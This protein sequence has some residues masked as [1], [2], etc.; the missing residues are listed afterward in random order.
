[1]AYRDFQNSQPVPAV[2]ET[3]ATDGLTYT[4]AK[5][6][7]IGNDRYPYGQ[8]TRNRLDSCIYDPAMAHASACMLPTS[9]RILNTY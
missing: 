4:L 5:L 1:M 8:K 6:Y 2:P 3:T 9:T 7:E